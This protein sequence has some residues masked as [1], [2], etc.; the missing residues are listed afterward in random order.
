MKI[1]KE[2]PSNVKGVALTRENS[3]GCW[4]SISTISDASAVTM[5]VRRAMR[6]AIEPLREIRTLSRLG[7]G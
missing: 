6:L 5:T 2:M 1:D 3:A 4:F 7:L